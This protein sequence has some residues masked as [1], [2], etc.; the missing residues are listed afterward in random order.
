MAFATEW[1][2]LYSAQRHNSVWP[3]SDLVSLFSRYYVSGHDGGRL[4]EV[5]CGAG[6]NIPFFQSVGVDYWGVDG[7]ESVVE[8]LRAAFPSFSDQ[9]AVCDFTCEIPFSG[10]FDVVVDRGS[11]THN[12]TGDIESGIELVHDIMTDGGYFIG[13]D[14][15]SDQHLEAQNGTVTVDKF[16][17]SGFETGTLAGVGF[18]HFATK[19]RLIELFGGFEILCLTHKTVENHIPNDNWR[20]GG[21]NFVCRK[22]GENAKG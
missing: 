21:W 6:A 12:A 15:F 1:E 9:L 10:S 17:R 7:S 13:V 19:E 14:W 20:F 4:L 3:W 18:A 2:S 22:P 8:R 5:G 11:F 16:T